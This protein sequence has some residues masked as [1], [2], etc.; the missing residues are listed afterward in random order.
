ML[1]R[2]GKARE[3]HTWDQSKVVPDWPAVKGPWRCHLPEPHPVPWEITHSGDCLWGFQCSPSSSGSFSLRC[4]PFHAGW[5]V[6]TRSRHLCAEAKHRIVIVYIVR[7][8]HNISIAINFMPFLPLIHHLVTG[9]NG[10]HYC[11]PLRVII[12]INAE[13]T[14]LSNLFPACWMQK[15]IIQLGKYIYAFL[16]G[17]WILHLLSPP[18]AE[19][20]VWLRQES[21][22]DNLE[23][24]TVS[25]TF[26]TWQNNIECDFVNKSHRWCIRQSKIFL[27]LMKFIASQFDSASCCINM[28]APQ[29]LSSF[30][31]YGSIKQKGIK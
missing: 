8:A 4:P 17:I 15:H 6:C 13:K 19:E 12:I 1:W 21:I 27:H 2:S 3:Y 10:F 30:N 16:K 18:G 9:V 29:H 20:T 23:V 25:F 26:I 11:G 5:E 28:H 7:N 24:R 22:T 14:I 31:I